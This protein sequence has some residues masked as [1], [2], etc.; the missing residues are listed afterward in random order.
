MIDVL[1]RHPSNPNVTKYFKKVEFISNL[2][3]IT[4]KR[5]R[6]LRILNYYEDF[7]RTNNKAIMGNFTVYLYFAHSFYH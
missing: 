5:T 6:L 3:G 2:E 7:Q 4:Q 1:K